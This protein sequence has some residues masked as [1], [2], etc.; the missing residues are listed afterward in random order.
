MDP[1]IIGQEHYD[2]AIQVQQILQE[3]KS[4]QDIIAI[5]GLD[6]LDEKS[7]LTVERAR[8]IQRFLSQ[9]FKV[10]E[11]FTGMEGK[12]VPLKE[13]IASFKSILNGEGDD[14]PE[15]AF[16]MVGG[17][18]EARAKGAKILADLEKS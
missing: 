15:A 14:L 13:S 18:D 7:K 10:A 11:A 4:L 6:E 1:R 5:L 17:F 2:V 16:Y 9:P 12:L 8:K 3:Y